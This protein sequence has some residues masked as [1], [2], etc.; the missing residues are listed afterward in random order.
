MCILGRTGVG[1]TWRVHT[2][3]DHFIEL[4]ADILRSKHDTL[5]FL[6][7]VKNSPS[8]I[9]LDEYETVSDLA[10]LREITQIPSRGLFVVASQIPVNFCFEIVTWECPVLG[11]AEIQK[12]FPNVDGTL[13]EKCKGNLW[14]LKHK[15]S[16]ACDD[17]QSP[18]EFIKSL[19][20]T[21]NPV[22]YVG[23]VW[24]EPGNCVSILQENYIDVKTSDLNFLCRVSE[25]FSDAD[26]FDSKIY[27]G[28]WDL[29][30]YHALTGYIIPAIEIGHRLG[31]DLRPGSLWT[32]YQNTCMRSKRIRVVLSRNPG[33]SHD[34]LCV[35]RIYIEHESFDILKEYASLD[36]DIFNYLNPFKKLSPK[37]MT[38]LKKLLV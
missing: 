6:E 5:N 8:P 7:R 28:N 31:P 25:S 26:V 12:A 29:A 9:F 2:G 21:H 14:L 22:D 16:D 20:T 10:G 17:F 34:A 36:V 38:R 23:A 15:H 27:E 33:L 13:I 35:L 32:K 30:P 37:V 4:T 24:A 19:V 18:K 3:L 1:K 11:P